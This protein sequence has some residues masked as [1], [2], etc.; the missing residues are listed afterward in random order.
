MTPAVPRVPKSGLRK[1][2]RVRTGLL[3]T[4]LL[5]TGLL[6]T[7]RTVA[8]RLFIGA[9]LVL[10]LGLQVPA[11][12]M[13]GLFFQPQLRDQKIPDADWQEIFGQVRRYGFDTLIL[14]WTRYGAAFADGAERAWLE[15]RIQQARDNDLRIIIGLAADPD[16]FSRSLQSGDALDAYLRRLAVNDAALARRWVASLPADAIAG[17]YLPAEIDDLNWRDAGR[18]QRLTA[19]LRDSVARLDEV[20]ERRVYISAFFTGKMQPDRYAALLGALRRAGVRLWVQDGRGT[21]VLTDAE[22]ALYLAPLLDCRQTP[23]DAVIH[24][25]YVRE[26]AANGDLGGDFVAR[27][28]DPA[29]VAALLDAEP[30]CR[31]R[32]FFFSLRYLPGIDRLMGTPGATPPGARSP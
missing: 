24:E 16:F 6:E 11:Q 23:I 27:G 7:G 19:Y 2:A 21:G 1:T 14:Q 29:R 12:A 9:M 8:R 18:A 13:T 31:G 10:A 20:L 3:E 28:L 5:K 4:D 15:A 25:I 22:A 30:P 32:R 26:P 17:W